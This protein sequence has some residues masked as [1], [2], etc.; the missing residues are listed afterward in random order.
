MSFI[1]LKM[2][3]ESKTY[4]L[5]LACIPQNK[6][7]KENHLHPK[8]VTYSLAFLNKAFTEYI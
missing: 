3:F 1:N 8:F 2:T 7:V 5:K 6:D 4:G